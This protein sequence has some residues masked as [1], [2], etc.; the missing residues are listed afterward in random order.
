MIPGEAVAHSQF[1]LLMQDIALLNSLGISLVIIHGSRPQIDERLT[2]AGITPRYHH[3]KR[4]TDTATLQAVQDA[5]GSV[6]V[7]IEALLSTGANQR[8]VSSNVVIAKPL[9]V[10]DGVDYGHTG[11]VRRVDHQTIKQLLAQHAIVLISHVG[12]SPTGE[13]FNLSVEEVAHEV[14]IAIKADKLILYGAQK[15]LIQNQTLVREL[16]TLEAETLLKTQPNNETARLLNAATAACKAG[17]ERTHLIGYAHDGALLEELFTHDG[18]GTLVTQ[19]PFE[20]IRQASINDVTGILD[21][22]IPLEE[23]DILVRRSRERLETDINHFTV[24]ERDDLII[25]CAA[26]HPLHD[27]TSA[28]IACLAIHP[29]YREGGRGDRLLKQLEKRAHEQHIKQ[30][31][32]LTTQT[33]H[34]FIERGFAQA[35][36]D[37]L[38]LERKSLYNFQRN[39]KVF[40]KSL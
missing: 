37:D 33:A 10:R 25:G 22:I 40:K 21:L 38:P 31:F 32:V 20:K 26:L 3:E 23:A 35:T 2:K 1:P 12:Y 15:G 39:S 14:A 6:R 29:D 16:T 5:A 28:E 9:G 36:V 13:V 27:K 7:Q 30:L 8:V 19:Q 4:I 17:V 11:C 18:A 24:C 34:W